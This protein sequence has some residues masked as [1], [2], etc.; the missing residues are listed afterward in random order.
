MKKQVTAS[1]PSK[2]GILK[3]A[4][5]AD[6]HEDQMPHLAYYHQDIDIKKPVV[7]RV[8]SECL[9]S[10]LLGSKRCDCGQQLQKSLEIISKEKGLLIYLRQEGRGIGL[11]NKLSAY[12]LQDQGLDTIAAN[13][14]LGFATDDRD[15]E[16]ARFILADLGIRKIRL[17][18]NNPLK[19][20]D[21]DQ[22]NIEIIERLPLLIEPELENK[23]YLKTKKDKMGHYL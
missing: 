11:I 10:D 18:T 14:Q 6:D 1:M 19:V 15:Y 9:T 17:L 5:F 16:I 21:L 2:W 8:H 22:G 3:I 4:A 13:H 23:A 12:N 7:V 20:S